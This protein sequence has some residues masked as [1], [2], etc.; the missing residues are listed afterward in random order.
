MVSH[1]LDVVEASL[2]TPFLLVLVSAICGGIGRFDSNTASECRGIE[3]V[4]R[5][6]NW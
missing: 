1:C 6:P 2:N 4:G 3:D 5:E